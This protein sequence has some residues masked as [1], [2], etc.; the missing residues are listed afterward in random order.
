MPINPEDIDSDNAAVP[1]SPPDHVI[2]TDLD[3]IEGVLVDLH[4]KQYYLLNETA[5]LI[6]RSLA[7]GMPVVS[8]AKEMAELYDVTME[9]AQASVETAVGNFMAHRLLCRH[10]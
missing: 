6:W 2:F 8:I 4:A 10:A 3:G 1:P 9:H 5:S 7:K